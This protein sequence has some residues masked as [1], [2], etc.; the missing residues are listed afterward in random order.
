MSF[1]RWVLDVFKKGYK[2]DLELDDL[3]DAL[4]EHSSGNLG[5]ELER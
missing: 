5:D 2:R 1:N 3:Y 4:D